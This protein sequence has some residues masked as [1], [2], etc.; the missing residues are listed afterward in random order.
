MF[1]LQK[2]VTATVVAALVALGGF[3]ATDATGAHRAGSLSYLVQNAGTQYLTKGGLTATFPGRLETGD[4]IFSRD[5]LLRGSTTIG[6]D[7][8]TCTVTFDAND[9]CRTIAVFPGKGDV[10]ATWLW[11]G[12]NTSLYGP[13]HFHGVIDGGTGSY[14]NAGGQFE[15]DSL[16]SGA[17]K[18]TAKLR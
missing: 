7:N 9:L 1:I 11:V 3:T 13:S 18:I 17:L 12:R 8:M 4:Q 16:P 2:A 6:Y 10:E 14:K 5:S 15:A